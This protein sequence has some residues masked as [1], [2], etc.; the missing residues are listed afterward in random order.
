[1]T[2]VKTT[3]SLPENQHKFLKENGYSASR[4]FQ[5]MTKELIKLSERQSLQAQPSDE[6]R[7][8][9]SNIV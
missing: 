8:G 4:L 2:F 9:G 5:N 3:I 1:M 7:V 6:P